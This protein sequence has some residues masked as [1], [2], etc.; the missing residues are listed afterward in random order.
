MRATP[1]TTQSA[2]PVLTVMEALCGFAQQGASNK[3]LAAACKLS[4]VTVTR[5]TQTLIA[6]GWCR[7]SDET[8]RFYPTAAFTRLTFKVLDSFN[9]AQQR[10]EDQRHSMTTSY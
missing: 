5:A 1:S 2:Q 6:Y 9:Q 8:G 7:K 3:D 10:L 4:A